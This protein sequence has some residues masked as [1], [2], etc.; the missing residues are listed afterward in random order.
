MPLIILSFCRIL[1]EG[2]HFNLYLFYTLVMKTTYTRMLKMLPTLALICLLLLQC[3]PSKDSTYQ[4]LLNFSD[5][6]KVINT[7]EHQH[8]LEDYGD[9]SF[10]LA[11]LIHASYLN[12]DIVSAGGQRTDMGQLDT[13]SIDDYWK[14]NGQRPQV[15]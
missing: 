7:H 13:L 4:S 9:H 12:A 5:Q 8:W 3:N 15:W 1:S 6:V 11:H 14:I 10:S 2:A